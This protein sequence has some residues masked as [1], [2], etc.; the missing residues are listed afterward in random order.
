ML[1]ASARRGL[2][3]GPTRALAGARAL[4]GMSRRVLRKPRGAPTAPLPA[5]SDHRREVPGLSVPVI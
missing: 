2:G 1:L 4:R 5:P 3:L